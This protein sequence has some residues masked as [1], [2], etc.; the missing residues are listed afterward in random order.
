[1]NNYFQAEQYTDG[2]YW[3]SGNLKKYRNPIEVQ[4][5]IKKAYLKGLEDGSS[6]SE[7]IRMD[8]RLIGQ[9]AYGYCSVVTPALPL[10]SI[11]E[12]KRS[13]YSV[14]GI[15]DVPFE[16][17]KKCSILELDCIDWTQSLLII[18]K[19]PNML[20][21]KDI[22]GGNYQTVITDS[23]LG[24]V[25]H[26][27]NTFPSNSAVAMYSFPA[28]EQLKSTWEFKFN[29][30]DIQPNWQV[31]SI[32][33]I[34]YGNGTETLILDQMGGTT[35]SSLSTSV[36]FSTTSGGTSTLTIPQGARW[37]NIAITTTTK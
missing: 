2:I 5:A 22:G 11:D 25:I 14:F 35:A 16:E 33:S 20:V 29:L 8:V 24:T 10:E 30:A 21:V 9:V 6:Q 17:L 23:V 36:Q 27:F 12:T 7:T 28:S 31:T 3:G 34:K 19:Q 4:K 26:C 15:L 1:M 18:E 13:G 37:I 32:G